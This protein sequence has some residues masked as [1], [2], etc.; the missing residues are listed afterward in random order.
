MTTTIIEFNQLDTDHPFAPQRMRIGLVV[1]GMTAPG[2]R[3]DDEGHADCVLPT[4][5]PI[6]FFADTGWADPVGRTLAAG[7]SGMSAADGSS[8]DSG[9]G[10]V[11]VGGAFVGAFRGEVYSYA[12][13]LRERPSYVRRELAVA[14]RVASTLLVIDVTDTEARHFERAW[15]S[16]RYDPG[17]FGIVGLNCSTHAGWAFASAGLLATPGRALGPALTS[18]IEGFDTPTDLYRQL[19]YGPANS[20]FVSYSGYLG[21]EPLAHGWYRVSIDSI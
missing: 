18:E 5:E 14:Q 21:F 2:R 7:S 20:R 10:S 11:M 4:G 16:M 1:R 13:Y 6:G 12:T 8:G 9:A 17:Q 3:P 15:T 19:V